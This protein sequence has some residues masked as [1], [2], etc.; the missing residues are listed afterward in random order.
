MT[1]HGRSLDDLPLAAYSTGVVPDEIEQPEQATEANLT[2][3]AFSVVTST[4]HDHGSPS[5]PGPDSASTARVG[6][7]RFSLRLPFGLP[8][9][10]RPKLTPID[11]ASAPFHAVHHEVRQPAAD[12]PRMTV[13]PLQP[14]PTVAPRT[15]AASSY[16]VA[17]FGA[18]SHAVSAGATPVAAM[19]RGPGAFLRDLGG[20]LRGPGALLRGSGALS[21]DPRA[22][23]R[24]PRVLVGGIVAVGLVLLVVSILGGA[25]SGAA[26]PDASHDTTGAQATPVPVANASIELTNGLTGIYELSGQTGVGPAVDSRLAATWTDQL[27]NTL[28][29][30]GLASAGTRTTDANFVLTWSTVV[31]GAP[32]TFTSTDG[33]CTIGMA[34]GAKAVNGTFVC[35]KLTSDDGSRT[36]DLRGSYRT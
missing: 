34:V 5:E 1:F 32:M 35:K 26:G 28:G 7:R 33:E 16:G 22:L 27:G 20:L 29:L 15:L 14:A 4:A 17:P 9:L 3:S 24:D 8:A 23:L 31:N 6:S 21:R 36:V 18:P 12:A 19:P 10:L 11:E 13:A 25:G 2:D 30:V